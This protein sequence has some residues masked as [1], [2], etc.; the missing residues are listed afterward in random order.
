MFRRRLPWL[1]AATLLLVYIGS[2]LYLA[3][4]GEAWSRPLGVSGF[5]YVLPDDT[6]RWW[7][8]HKVSFFV[9]L[10]ANWVD[11]QIGTGRR[12]VTSIMLSDPTGRAVWRCEAVGEFD[13]D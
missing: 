1:L 9:Y 5:F 7:T 3:S 4:R 11:R 6:P 2:Y 10:P 12:P 13:F 8:L